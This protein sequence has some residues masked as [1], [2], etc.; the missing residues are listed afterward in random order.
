MS[1]IAAVAETA[2]AQVWE[3]ENWESARNRLDSF[4]FEAAPI[5]VFFRR[6]SCQQSAGRRPPARTASRDGGVKRV[7]FVSFRGPGDGKTRGRRKRALGCVRGFGEPRVEAR[8][9]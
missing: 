9:G 3:F 1:L 8:V 4:D 6:D 5:V 7:V 2:R